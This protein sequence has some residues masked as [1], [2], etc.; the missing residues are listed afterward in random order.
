[1]SRLRDTLIERYTEHYARANATTDPLTLSPECRKSMELTYGPLVAGLRPNA[2]VLDL[3][4]GS[5]FLLSWLASKPVAAVG[6]DLCPGQIALARRVPNVEVFCDDA[7]DYLRRHPCEFAAIF[8]TDFMEHVPGEDTLLELTQAAFEALEPDGFLLCK[9][10]NAANLA[11]THLRYIDMTHVRSFT[12][13]S[14]FQ[15][16]DAA[17]FQRPRVV[18][19]AAG[20]YRGRIRMAV[21]AL[22][23]KVVFRICGRS[24]NVFTNVVCAVGFK[25]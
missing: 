19:I 5:G 6:V 24:E 10:P 20:H 14:L 15:L 21:E 16:L 18:P 11:G 8:C 4:C 17:G 7:L 22:L 23:H 25:N 2:R 9:V 12:S 3:A 1:M 13:T